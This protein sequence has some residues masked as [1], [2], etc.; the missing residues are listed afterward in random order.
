MGGDYYYLLAFIDVCPFPY[1]VVKAGGQ[2]AGKTFFWAL[3]FA[4]RS[5]VDG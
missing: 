1:L 4:R 3:N 5:R 2:R